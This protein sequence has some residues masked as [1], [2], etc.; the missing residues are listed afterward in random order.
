MAI[1][2]TNTNTK[3]IKEE[4]K[5]ENNMKYAVKVS[6][7]KEIPNRAGCY[8]FQLEVNGVTIYG[9]RYIHFTSKYGKEGDLISFPSYKGSDDK[10]Y[11]NCWFPCGSDT[12]AFK[13]IEKQ[14]EVIVNGK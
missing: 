7:V 5:M 4:K 8:R 2:K 9:M 12:E 3:E 6:N 11:N 13:E 10:F 14:L 1:K